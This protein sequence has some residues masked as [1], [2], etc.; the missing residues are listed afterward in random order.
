VSAVPAGYPHE[1]LAS[2]GVRAMLTGNRW[3]QIDFARGLCG[4]EFSQWLL[5][6]PG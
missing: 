6:S 2:E 3:S 5:F 4:N 1:L